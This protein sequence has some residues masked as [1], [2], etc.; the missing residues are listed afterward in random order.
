MTDGSVEAAMCQSDDDCIEACLNGRPDTFRHLVLRY[1]RPMLA[2]LT[3][4]LG[5]PDA[6]AE[7]AQESFVRAY[8]RLGT[9]QRGDAFFAWLLGIAQ[10]VMLE[11]FRRRR[12]YSLSESTEP[13]DPSTDAAA[14]C[15]VELADAVARLPDPYRDVTVLRYF[16]GLTC[17]E[18]SQRLGVPLGTVTKRLSR[19]YGLLREALATSD[20]R[21]TKV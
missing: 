12:E 1:E 3:R 13:V 14:D 7:V 6:A 16:G 5:D 10:R 2:Y 19:A 18:V 9:L 15:D 4:R 21:Q 20:D 8:F 11:S 17:A